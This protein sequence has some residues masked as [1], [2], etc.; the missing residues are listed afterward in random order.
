[1]HGLC[2]SSKHV[3]DDGDGFHI[4]GE[5]HPNILLGFLQSMHTS[6]QIEYAGVR[7]CAFVLWYTSIKDMYPDWVSLCV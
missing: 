7:L 5:K 4:C 1:M 6:V 3:K 2:Y